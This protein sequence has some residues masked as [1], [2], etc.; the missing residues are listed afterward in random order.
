MKFECLRIHTYI[1][2][3]STVSAGGSMGHPQAASLSAKDTIGN[4]AAGVAVS[5]DVA[6]GVTV[7]VW[8]PEP[9]AFSLKSDEQPFA[10]RAVL[11]SRRARETDRERKSSC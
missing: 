4:V 3:I 10:S 7:A 11:S 9:K 2:I 8:Q 1:I 6:V 5:V